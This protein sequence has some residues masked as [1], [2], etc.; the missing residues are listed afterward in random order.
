VAKGE[1][2]VVRTD[3]VIAEI[4]TLGATLKRIELLKH[5]DTKDAAQNLV[6]LGPE[7]QYEAQSGLTG[8]GGPN[9]RTLWSVQPG[10]TTPQPAGEEVEARRAR[11][12][13]RRPRFTASS[14]T[15]M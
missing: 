3:L 15:V 8:D 9:H 5:K 12:A 13:W 14:A 4:D 6:L 10:N 2:V 1:T 11:T 7:H